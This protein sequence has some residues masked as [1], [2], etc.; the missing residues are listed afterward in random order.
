M[1]CVTDCVLPR[2]TTLDLGTALYPKSRK[3]ASESERLGDVS[4]GGCRM[5][6][7]CDLVAG[8]MTGFTY[9][10]FYKG[11]CGLFCVDTLIKTPHRTHVF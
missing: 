6:A 1:I 10:A 11:Y 2:M 8:K 3:A 7:L 4:W 9:H 5:G